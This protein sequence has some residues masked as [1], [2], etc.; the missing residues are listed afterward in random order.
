M[1]S[2]AAVKQVRMITFKKVNKW[3]GD[4]HV[5]NDVDFHVENNEEGNLY[6]N[7]YDLRL[8]SAVEYPEI[9]QHLS[10]YPNVQSVRTIS[11]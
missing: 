5:L 10:E 2:I 8:T 1:L 9:V 6:T 3:F 11:V 4:L 7:T